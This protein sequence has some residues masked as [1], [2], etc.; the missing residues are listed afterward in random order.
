MRR[1]KRL[2][3]AM[4][5]IAL[6]LGMA[7][8]SEAAQEAKAA[9]PVQGSLVSVDTD[10][11]TIA[12]RTADNQTMQFQYTDETKI[13]GAQQNVAGLAGAKEARVTVTFRE[14]GKA[15]VATQI[16]VQAAK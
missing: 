5:A 11:K 15:R 4:A 8:M 16:E 3:F 13:S 10:A 12:V 6:I 14:Q 7:G 1:T 2:A 9:A